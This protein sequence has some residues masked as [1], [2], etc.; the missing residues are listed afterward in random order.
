MRTHRYYNT[1]SENETNDTG[2]SKINHEFDENR[3]GDKKNIKTEIKHLTLSMGA[4]KG[5]SM[6]PTGVVNTIEQE[7][8]RFKQCLEEFQESYMDLIKLDPFVI[9]KYLESK[10][11]R[12]Y[13]KNLDHLTI[14]LTLNKLNYVLSQKEID[15]EATITNNQRKVYKQKCRND[16]WRG[17]PFEKNVYEKDYQPVIYEDY[18]EPDQPSDY[19]SDQHEHKQ[20]SSSKSKKNH[21][22]FLVHGYNGRVTDMKLV[23]N[24]LLMRYPN[25]RTYVCKKISNLNPEEGK[26]YR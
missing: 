16:N 3:P 21:L 8:A 22:I 24:I 12:L 9:F 18:W 17:L 26:L 4:S 19:D 13:T 23:R 11:F 2:P 1:Y 14:D 10:Y 6:T 25:C 15:K 5:I 7:K 20:S